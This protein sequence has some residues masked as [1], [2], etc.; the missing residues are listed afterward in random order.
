MNFSDL[1]QFLNFL[2]ARGQLVRVRT[3]V[4]PNQEITVIQH[5]V[6]AQDG[7]ALLFERVRNSPYRLVS[8]LFGTRQRVAWAFGEAPAELGRR[9]VYLTQQLMPPSPL[10]LWRCR[11]D[12]LPLVHAR[13]RTV[14]TGPITETL[15]TLPDLLKLP[16]LTCWPGDGG[17]FLTLPLV[18]TVDPDDGR[19][20]LAI[21][22]LQRFDSRCTGM[23][24]QI[25]KG[26]G[27]HFHKAC[28]RGRSLPVSVILG[29]PPSLIIAAIAP[30]PEGVDERLL[31]AYITG[32]PLDVLRRPESG[33]LIPAKAE[34]VLEGTVSPG[35]LRREGPFGDHFGH[36]SQAADY[37][38]L[39][40]KRLLARKDA[41]YPATVV[42]K[43]I[44][45]DYYLGEA[46]QEMTLPLLKLMRPAVTDLWAYPETGF[47]P[48][49]VMAVRERYPREALKHALGLLGEGQVSLTKVMIA[50]NDGVAVRDFWQVSRALWRHLDAEE[51]IFLLTP[52]AQDTLDFTGPA[53]NTGSRLIL[54]AAGRRRPL[55]TTPPPPPPPPAAVDRRIRRLASFG[56]AFLLVQ[57]AEGHLDV[58]SLRAALEWHPDTGGYLFQVLLSE[59]IELDDPV[60]TLW[61]WFSRFDPQK[62]LHAARTR[63]SDNHLVFDFPIL[64]D[65][66]WKRGYPQPVAF[67]PTVERLVSRRWSE[68]G[69]R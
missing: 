27:F 3:Q 17:P 36:Y 5:R 44:Q 46:L 54:M 64:I 18:H 65:A 60:M 2:E 68:Y 31:A 7:P 52:T 10:K 25:E 37:P 67:D 63:V 50:V 41:I 11:K 62:D 8:N 38:V 35:D 47:H 16:V 33:H 43:P 12:L 15:T 42:G 57:V 48:L 22:R 4:N 24:W 39:R 66:R 30:L 32:K 55:R 19:G 53:L 61:G 14:A 45:E 56:P 13:L 9:L 6:M 28:R 51:G 1:R 59:D 26:G 49:A 21:Y 69:I 23:H 58:G 34:F 40:V 29:G 20:N